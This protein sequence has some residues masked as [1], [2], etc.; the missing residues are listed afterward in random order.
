MYQ[1]CFQLAGFQGTSGRSSLPHPV[2]PPLQH[3]CLDAAPPHR[4]ELERSR[5]ALTHS[6]PGPRYCAPGARQDRIVPP[7]HVEVRQHLSRGRL[8]DA[9]NEEERPDERRADREQTPREAKAII[10]ADLTAARKKT[11]RLKE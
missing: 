5:L 7:A 4:R 11:V 10:H 6:P 3:A 8:S 1:S 9:V 2:R